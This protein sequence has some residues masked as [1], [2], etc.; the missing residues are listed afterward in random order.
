MTSCWYLTYRDLIRLDQVTAAPLATLQVEQALLVDLDTNK[1]ANE[2]ERHIVCS[3]YLSIRAYWPT[4]ILLIDNH[5][6]CYFIELAFSVQ[7]RS[8]SYNPF[9]KAILEF[10]EHLLSAVTYSEIL[11]TAE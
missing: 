8:D 5:K 2:T 1:I 10:Y 3:D 6:K 11:N 7:K 4:L 9:Q